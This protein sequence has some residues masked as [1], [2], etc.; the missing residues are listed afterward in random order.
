MPTPLELYN[1]IVADADG[2]GFKNPDDSWKEDQEIADLFNSGSYTVSRSEIEKS[3]VV[4]SVIYDEYN[5]L[6]ADEQEWI[7]WITAGDGFLKVSA[8]IKTK[9]TNTASGGGIWPNTGTVSPSAIL[10]L[11]EFTGTYAE[12]LWGEGVVISSGDVGRAA[13]EG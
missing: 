4:S 2:L 10:A 8:D 5:G 13:N 6:V 9:L 11:I 12:S 7:R 3:D 1:V